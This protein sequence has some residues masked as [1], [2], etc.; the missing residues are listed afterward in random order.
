MESL[1]ESWGHLWP[2]WV[3]KRF[4]ERQVGATMGQVEAKMSQ[5]EVKLGPSWGQ[6]GDQWGQI[7]AKLVPRCFQEG[8]KRRQVEVPGCFLE[9]FWSTRVQKC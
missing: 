9:H 3:P 4:W 2:T 6:V 8:L 7:G 1:G 5:E